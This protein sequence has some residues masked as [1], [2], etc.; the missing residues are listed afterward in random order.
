VIAGRYFS[1]ATSQG[2]VAVVRIEAGGL[3]WLQAGELQR[4]VPLA[5]VRISERIGNTPRYIEFNDGAR[6][7]T[8]DNDALDAALAQA[9]Q[10]RFHIADAL[11]SRWSLVL[12]ALCCVLVVGYLTARFGVPMLADI[13]AEHMP[14][15]TTQYLGRQVLQAMQED[16]MTAS[17]LPPAR[18][19]T[20][21]K[22]FAEMLQRTGL[23]PDIE[24][25]FYD[26]E[27][28]GANA[29]ALPAGIVVMT[30]QL[31]HLAKHDDEIL[32]VLAHELGH[33]A[34][35]HALRDSIRNSI[36]SF[37]ILWFSGDVSGTA[38]FVTSL[39]VLLL[40]LKYSREF[41]Q[42]AD[43]FALQYALQHKL[44]TRHYVCILR[45]LQRKDDDT[46]A[47][48]DPDELFGGFLSTH[49]PTAARL[50][51]FEEKSSGTACN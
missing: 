13:L 9:Q 41:E 34:H 14:E 50:Q 38:T 23:T 49:P 10:W 40:E 20:L 44:D 26:A 27:A 22:A 29:F 31:V 21:Q 15:R 43:A 12:L 32:A 28:I 39:P 42:E 7:E 18:Q 11:E 8:L 47:A 5:H 45:R 4:S 25:Y 48:V 3:L 6:F 17:K 46:D 19:A 36:L 16:W 51:A 1:G 33:V 30:D 37:L 2:M 35:N 24:L